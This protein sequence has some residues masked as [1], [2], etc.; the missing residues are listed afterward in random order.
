MK[1]ILRS[2]IGIARVVDARRSDDRCK[3]G[4]IR[5]AGSDRS[6]VES[7]S[8]ADPFRIRKEVSG[9]SEEEES[10]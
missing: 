8:G 7:D 6:T 3:P 4:F 9:H 5:D 1:K 2:P 10:R